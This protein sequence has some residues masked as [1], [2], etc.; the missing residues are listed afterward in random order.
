MWTCCSWIWLHNCHLSWWPAETPPPP[1][2]GCGPGRW[3]PVWCSLT[4]WPPLWWSR[5]QIGP[6]SAGPG[7]RS[8][9]TEHPPGPRSVSSAPLR[10][11]R[12]GG[13]RRSRKRKIWKQK[14]QSV[15]WWTD[16]ERQ[17]RLPPHRD[18]MINQSSPINYWSS[19][20][21]HS[22]TR[23]D[24]IGTFLAQVKLFELGSFLV[25]LC[26][27][28]LF[29]SDEVGPLLTQRWLLLQHLWWWWRWRENNQTGLRLINC[30]L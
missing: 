11:T 2:T 12:K 1:A 23:D 18:L 8:A 4:P 26:L 20:W 15:W 5:S 9:E 7:L 10:R 24:M 25:E 19:G 28:L 27:Q 29:Q 13:R 3:L 6:G 22:L 21:S 30:S 17:C 16:T 14:Q